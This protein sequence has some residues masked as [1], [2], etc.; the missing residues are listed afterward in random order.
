MTTTPEATATA[1]TTEAA[2]ILE[3]MGSG[4]PFAMPRKRKGKV[5]KSW[6]NAMASLPPQMA[7]PDPNAPKPLPSVVIGHVA[8]TRHDAAETVAALKQA[9]D[10]LDDYATK[11]V[12][13]S[14]EGFQL[15]TR[16]TLAL[17]Q[18]K[19]RLAKTTLASRR[20]TTTMRRKDCM[21]LTVDSPMRPLGS[22]AEGGSKFDE[23]I[24][25]AGIE[26]W[27]LSLRRVDPEAVADLLYLI[28]EPRTK[29]LFSREAVIAHIKHLQAE[30]LLLL[31]STYLERPGVVEA[32]KK[33]HA[34][35]PRD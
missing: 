30:A 5:Y 16:L 6:T 10:L 15:S 28:A 7:A 23:R 9:L 35:V 17:A 25:K 27:M 26:G 22:W 14:D 33:M 2:E 19:A 21:P 18:A 20:L 32:L 1:D 24:E 34:K 29:I 8:I 13:D 11:T 4:T 12:A 3:A 31:R